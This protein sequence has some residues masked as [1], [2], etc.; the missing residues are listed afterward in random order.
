MAY[1]QPV[2]RGSALCVLVVMGNVDSVPISTSPKHANGQ[3]QN[4]SRRLEE[5]Y[6]EVSSEMETFSREQMENEFTKIVVSY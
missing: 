2:R 6:V 1:L 5:E 3:N 4:F